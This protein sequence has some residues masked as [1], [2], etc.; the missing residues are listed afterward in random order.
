LP[1]GY[2][3]ALSSGLWPSLDVLPDTERR[4]TGAPLDVS[5]MFW[6]KGIKGEPHT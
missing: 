4:A 3:A 2:A 1:D 6:P 5:D